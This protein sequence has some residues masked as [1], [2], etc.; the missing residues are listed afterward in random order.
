MY[1]NQQPTIN[2]L[3]AVVVDTMNLN[4]GEYEL[5]ITG[6]HD[7]RERSVVVP[8]T[9]DNTPDFEIQTMDP[10]IVLPGGVPG[11]FQ[12]HIFIEPVNG[13]GADVSLSAR[14]SFLKG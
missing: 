1:D 6:T 10:W 7:G 5:T 14:A 13:F 3:G 12:R 2:D 8:F 9:V 11:S 4:G